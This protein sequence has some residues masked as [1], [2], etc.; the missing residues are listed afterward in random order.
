VAALTIRAYGPT[1]LRHM[2]KLVLILA[3]VGAF[4]CAGTASAWNAGTPKLDVIAT[5]VAGHPVTVWCETDP[6]TW[7]EL[8]GSSPEMANVLGFTYLAEPI[9]YVNPTD[10]RILR[11]ASFGY[12]PADTGLFYLA[13]AIRDL[14]HESVH[15]RGIT[16]EGITD[17]TA[18]V[19]M[20]E[21]AVRFFGFNR[22]AV[23][24]RGR[25]KVRVPDPALARLLEWAHAWHE[26]SPAQYQGDC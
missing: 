22:T 16:D 11:L 8:L 19:A 14:V 24:R 15:Q 6:E 10:C 7:I 5:D 26:E 12:D 9:V 25:R 4:A 20:P 3:F 21:V 13:R 2:K 1:T 23:V 17:C 18:L